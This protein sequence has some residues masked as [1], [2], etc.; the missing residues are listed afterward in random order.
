MNKQY[1]LEFFHFP[2]CIIAANKL[3]DEHGDRE[4][5]ALIDYC[6]LIHWLKDPVKLPEEIRHNINLCA[7]GELAVFR[8]GYLAKSYLCALSDF[9]DCFWWRNRDRIRQAKTTGDLY[10]LYMELYQKSGRWCLPDGVQDPA[11]LADNAAAPGL[12]AAH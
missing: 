4:Q 1:E 10:R 12:S 6:G 2:G 7:A 3:H 11:E 8:A 9:P 5:L